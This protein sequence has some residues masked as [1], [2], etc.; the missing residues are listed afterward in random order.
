MHFELKLV[1]S[2]SNKIKFCDSVFTFQH[3]A[4]YSVKTYFLFNFN[5]Q[6]K[7]VREERK[8]GFLMELED[9]I[10]KRK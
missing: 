4:E 7:T 8:T 6:Y 10:Q 3:I 1:L 9:P 2:G 5:Y